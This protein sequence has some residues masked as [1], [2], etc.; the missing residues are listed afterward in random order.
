MISQQYPS[1]LFFLALLLSAHRLPACSIRLLL[2]PSLLGRG[3][4]C[5]SLV[6]VIAA[7]E[8]GGEKKSEWKVEGVVGWTGRDGKGGKREGRS[9]SDGRGVTGGRTGSAET[10][11]VGVEVGGRGS[12]AAEEA[13]SE[14]ERRDMR[15]GSVGKDSGKIE[16]VSSYSPS[17]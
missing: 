11:E 5:R 6:A 15:R 16:A 1:L 13:A 14:G 10:V 3:S 17:K 4:L 8:G 7:A 12:N 9:R 2:L